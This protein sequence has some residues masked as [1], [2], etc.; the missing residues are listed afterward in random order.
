MRGMNWALTIVAVVMGLGIVLPAS[1]VL[2]VEVWSPSPNLLE[3]KDALGVALGGDGR[4]Y[5]VAGVTVGHG[6]RVELNTVEVLNNGVWEFLPAATNE[7]RA[8]VRCVTDSHGRI[9]AIGGNKNTGTTLLDSVEVYDPT[10]PE[11]G[12]Q[13]Q[14]SK[15]KTAR[16]GMGIAIGGDDSIF[17]FGGFGPGVA[18]NTM[19]RYDPATQEW[20][21]LP[22]TMNKLRGGHGFA[23]DLQGRIYAIGGQGGVNEQ[24]AERYDPVHPDLG[25]QYVANLPGPRGNPTAF[26][27]N[28]E[29]WA[30]GGWNGSVYTNTTYIYNPN[31]DSWTTGPEMYERLRADAIVDASGVPW[32]IGGQRSAGVSSNHVAFLVPEPSTLVLLGVGAIGFLAWAWRRRRA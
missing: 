29:I 32:L 12:W 2:A 13:M 9:W 8:G 7:P 6:P 18:L 31:T 19:E 25:W 17:I 30:V 14:N 22:A 23:T 15:L 28:G 16:E 27:L 11:L 20:Q 26:T 10:H 4:I 3:Y 21:T 1:P 24:T 5:A